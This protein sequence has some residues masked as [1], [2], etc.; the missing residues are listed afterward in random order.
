MLGSAEITVWSIGHST[1]SWEDF[2]ALLRENRIERLVDVRHFP[3]SAH[4]PW[5]NRG[6]LESNL[7]GAGIAYERL[8]ELGGYRKPRPD[9][10]NLGWRNSGFRGYADYMGTPEF[11]AALD[12]LLDRA[13]SS[14]TAYMCAEAVPWKCHRSLLSDAIVARGARVVH[15]LSPEKAQAHILTPFARVHGNRVTYPA[16]RA[17][18]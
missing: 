9:S 11:E 16:A 14:R 1:R 4:V 2:L 15:I 7:P 18:R 6:T 3:S 12:V 5:A 13:K 17:K 10:R 8:V